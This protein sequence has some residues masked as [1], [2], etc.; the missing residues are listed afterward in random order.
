[1]AVT[2]ALR[3]EK[4]RVA[5]EPPAP[6]AG[7]PD[8]G[9]NRVQ[10]TVKDMAYFGSFTVYHLQLASGRDP[11]DQPEQHRAPGREPDL[12]RQRLGELV[13][14]GAG[15]ADAMSPLGRRGARSR[16]AGP[17]AGRGALMRG[18]AAGSP[19]AAVIGIPY[20]WLAVFFL[21]PFLVVARISV[22]EMEATTFKDIVSWKDGAIA[23]S[24]NFGNYLLLLQDSLYF[25]TFLSSLK[26]AAV[27]TLLCLAIGYPFAYF[28]A[29]ARPLAAAGPADAG[30][31][32]VLDLV[33]APRLRLEGAAHRA[34][35]GGRGDR[36]GRP[37]PR[38]RRA[39]ASCPGRAS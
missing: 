23:F 2:V 39:S 33:P 18:C 6:E 38:A 15:G 31:A 26:Y 36:G 37:R 30:D 19:A 17:A 3:P 25:S 34:G 1:M 14:A 13:G 22:S 28:M 27:T 12:G 4:I 21:L 11:Q 32:A 35:P 16:S 7:V 9:F 29:R 5:A 20:V 8:A 10:G 24:L